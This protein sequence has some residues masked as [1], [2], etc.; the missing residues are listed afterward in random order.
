MPPV[1]NQKIGQTLKNIEGELLNIR[2]I[3]S[4][5]KSSPFN[6]EKDLKKELQKLEQKIHPDLKSLKNELSQAYQPHL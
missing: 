2:L 3:L 1:L 4:A 5:S 6:S